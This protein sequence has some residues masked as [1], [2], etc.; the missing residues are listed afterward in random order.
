MT[1]DWGTHNII[2][3]DIDKTKVVLFF[4]ARKQK[5]LQQLTAI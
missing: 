3:Y 1:L 5:L 4:I 2:I